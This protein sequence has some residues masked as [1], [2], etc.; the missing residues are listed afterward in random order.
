MTT[1]SSTLWGTE[2]R[3]EVVGN[4]VRGHAAVFGSVAVV[5]EGYERIE[6]GAF[7]AAISNPDTDMRAFYNH[8][9]NMLLGRQKAHTL[10]VAPD[11]VGLEFEIDLPDTSYARDAKE[12]IARGDVTGA[13]FGFIPGDD[14]WD[15]APDGRRIRSHTSVEKLVEV[16]IVPFPAYEDTTVVLRSIPW[17]P[18]RRV[19]TYRDRLIRHRLM[20]RHLSREQSK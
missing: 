1:T 5:P 6:R 16:S 12:L 2:L 14:R 15:R 13:S 8:D 17:E 9:H 4:K 11:S 7:D 3:A 19:A 18:S 10:R 20:T